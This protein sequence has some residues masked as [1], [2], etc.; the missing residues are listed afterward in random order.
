LRSPRT[1]ANLE[2]LGFG[3][4][5]TPTESELKRALR[6]MAMQWHPDRPHNKEKPIEATEKFRA[7]KQAYDTLLEEHRSM[8][9]HD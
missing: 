8:A 7:G 9:R 4:H 1:I 3:P 5:A 2:A 6:D